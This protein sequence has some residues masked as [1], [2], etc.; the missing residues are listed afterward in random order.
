MG[1]APEMLAG[2]EGSV[3][4]AA[5]LRA[6]EAKVWEAVLEGDRGRRE[7]SFL[8]RKRIGTRLARLR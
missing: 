1:P 2:L 5:E 6:G 3:P 8:D 7:L 4:D